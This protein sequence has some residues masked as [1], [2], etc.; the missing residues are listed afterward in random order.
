MGLGN[1]KQ[2]KWHI[3][4]LRLPWIFYLRTKKQPLIVDLVPFFGGSAINLCL[5]FLAL[6]FSHHDLKRTFLTPILQ[7]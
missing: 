3:L 5:S 6:P 7:M 2:E 4:V 1:E